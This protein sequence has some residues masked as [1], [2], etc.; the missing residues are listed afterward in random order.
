MT[1]RSGSLLYALPVFN[2]RK[3]AEGMYVLQVIRVYGESGD[4]Q[5]SDSV[6]P[7]WSAKMS[8]YGDIDVD[9]EGAGKTSGPQQLTGRA[10]DPG[11]RRQPSWE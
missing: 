5:F 8:D 6:L 1:I 10:H 7:N 2:G 3:L 11:T 9:S 4:Q